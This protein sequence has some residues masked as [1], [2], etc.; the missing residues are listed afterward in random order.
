MPAWCGLRHYVES[1]IEF[2]VEIFNVMLAL[3]TLHGPPL[4]ECVATKIVYL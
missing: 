4:A 1:S 3:R 2:T